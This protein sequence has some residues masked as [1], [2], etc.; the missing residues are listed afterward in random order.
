MGL[1]SSNKG[2]KSSFSK[3]TSEFMKDKLFG[4][5]L[6][7][8]KEVKQPVVKPLESYFKKNILRGSQ[9]ADRKTVVQRLAED[10]GN[11]LYSIDHGKF[12][13]DKRIQMSKKLNEI[14]KDKKNFIGENLDDKDINWIKNELKLGSQGK[15]GKNLSKMSWQQKQDFKKFIDVMSKNSP[16]N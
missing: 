5:P 12:S 9:F 4:K 6:N 13:R 3:P 14:W 15:L 10:K 7:S 11:K 8:S 2:S 1:F 16:N